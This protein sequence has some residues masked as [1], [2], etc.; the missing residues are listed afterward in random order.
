MSKKYRKTVYGWDVPK[1]LECGGCGRRLPV[2]RKESEDMPEGSI[3]FAYCDGC[4]ARVVTFCGFP[5]WIEAVSAEFS[6][7][8]SE[9]WPGFETAERTMQFH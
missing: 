1:H 3:L 7:T 2:N 5:W 8:M 9:Y 4:G 6:R